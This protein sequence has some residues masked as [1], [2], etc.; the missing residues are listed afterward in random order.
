MI[1]DD[2]KALTADM[3]ALTSSEPDLQKRAEKSRPLFLRMV[4]IRSRL[5]DEKP[6]LTAEQWQECGEEVQGVIRR[7]RGWMEESNG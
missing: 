4:E 7:I 1:L 5:R 6:N 2:L 3:D